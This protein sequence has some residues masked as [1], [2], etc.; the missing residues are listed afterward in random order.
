MASFSAY[1]YLEGH[2]YGLV[3][4]SYTFHQAVDHRGRPR[5]KVRKGPIY[6][7]LYGLEDC[8]DLTEWMQDAFW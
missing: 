1:L 2:V 5:S 3:W 8:A 6:V 4:C 7:E